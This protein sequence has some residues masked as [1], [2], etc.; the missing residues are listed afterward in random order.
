MRLVTGVYRRDRSSRTRVTGG[1]R[2][3]PEHVNPERVR[4]RRFLMVVM[5]LRVKIRRASGGTHAGD[6]GQKPRRA[7]VQ[8]RRGHLQVHAAMRLRVP[9]ER[10]GRLP[11]SALW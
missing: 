10:V 1:V 2:R 9:L 5:V 8:C 3:D 11:L 6:V 7:G 4:K